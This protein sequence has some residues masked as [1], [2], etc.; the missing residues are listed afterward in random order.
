MLFSHCSIALTLFY[1]CVHRSAPEQAAFS[2]AA[3]QPHKLHHTSGLCNR[4]KT[5]ES[6]NSQRSFKHEHRQIES[7][8]WNNHLKTCFISNVK[9]KKVGGEILFYSTVHFGVLKHI[10]FTGVPTN[11]DYVYIIIGQLLNGE[12]KARQYIAGF[13]VKNVWMLLWSPIFKDS[14]SFV[15][16]I[17][18]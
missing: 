15:I 14:R 17:T 6:R 9:N 11:E 2:P 7:S 4:A 5:A 16:R 18:S 13:K 3:W 12:R 1:F 10:E 8:E